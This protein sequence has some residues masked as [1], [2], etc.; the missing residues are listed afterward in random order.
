MRTSQIE[1]STMMHV[2]VR[3]G[4]GEQTLKGLPLEVS[5]SSVA[6]TLPDDADHVLP[7]ITEKVNLIFD[8]PHL[9]QPYEC[10]AYTMYRASL[11]GVARLRFGVSATAERS[12][13]N[14]PF[15]RAAFRALL[16]TNDPTFAHVECAGDSGGLQAELHDVALGG[17]S[18]LVSRFEDPEF[19]TD[20]DLSVSFSLPQMSALLC[21]TGTVRY[22]K[23]V[24]EKVQY[25]LR[26]D[27]EATEH[28][29][30]MQ[31]ILFEYILSRQLE[32][33]RAMNSGT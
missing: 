9:P 24:G 6:V 11:H 4:G 21:I 16:K 12:L 1:T 28:A 10:P 7:G 8:G 14:L 3:F 15:Q 23:P 30:R 26:F 33:L 29:A 25:G 32:L 17:L 18:F 27:F 13:R 5:R 2:L 20:S 31:D 22:S 19:A